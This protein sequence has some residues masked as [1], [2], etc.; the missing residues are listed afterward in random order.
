MR[1]PPEDRRLI[2]VSAF[3]NLVELKKGEGMYVV[4]DGLHAWLQGGEAEPAFL[5]EQH[6]L[7]SLG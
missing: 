2:P 7:V 3:M 6:L 4:A 1:M 5:L